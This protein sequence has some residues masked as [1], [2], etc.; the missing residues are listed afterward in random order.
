MT[1]PPEP[2]GPPPPPYQ[3]AWALPAPPD[4]EKAKKNKDTRN[5][6]GCMLLLAAAIG[7]GIASCGGTNTTT[8]PSSD[9]NPP[10]AAPADTTTDPAPPPSTT[11]AH[12]A[13]YAAAARIIAWDQNGGN[14]RLTALN[15][16]FTQLS[17]D[18]NNNPGNVAADCQQISADTNKA[19]AYQHVPDTAAQKHWAAALADFKHGAADC[20]QGVN[21]SDTAQMAKGANEISAGNTQVLAVAKR[22]TAITNAMK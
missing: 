16:D 4:S 17:T 11:P 6:C 14:D 12:N 3:P 13:A 7:I 1:H 8:S 18:A 5:G 19:A 9:T 15:T 20:T 21:N 10:A 22:F 2:T